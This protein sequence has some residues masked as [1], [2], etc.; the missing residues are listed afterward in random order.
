MNK[1]KIK[2]NLDGEQED[3]I[4]SKSLKRAYS[5][6]RNLPDPH[7]LPENK[8]SL[9]EAFKLVYEYYSGKSLK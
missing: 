7:E 8:E 6:V 1:F 5:M 3:K 9:I 2:I 4:V